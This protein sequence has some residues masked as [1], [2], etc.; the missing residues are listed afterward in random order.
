MIAI[1]GTLFHIQLL[2]MDYERSHNNKE[3]ESNS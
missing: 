3:H 1:L 2:F